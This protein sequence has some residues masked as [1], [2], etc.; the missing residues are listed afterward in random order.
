MCDNS[1]RQIEQALQSA[2][3]AF[4]RAQKDTQDAFLRYTNSLETERQARDAVA[5]AEKRRDN[6]SVYLW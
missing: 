1:D 3:A 4:A 5:A 2:R 6:I